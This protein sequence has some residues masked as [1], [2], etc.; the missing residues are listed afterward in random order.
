MFL[1]IITLME[2]LVIS[3]LKNEFLNDNYVIITDDDSA[4]LN[5]DYTKHY[6]LIFTIGTITIR[7]FKEFYSM[8]I[9][10]QPQ[11]IIF[12]V[13]NLEYFL[14]TMKEFRN[15][16]YNI[17]IESNKKQLV[18]SKSRKLKYIQLEKDIFKKYNSTSKQKIDFNKGIQLSFE[19]D[20]YKSIKTSLLNPQLYM[21]QP[22]SIS[23]IC[24]IIFDKKY[25]TIKDIIDNIKDEKDELIIKSLLFTGIIKIKGEK[26]VIN[27]LLK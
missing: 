26:V 17:Q 11:Q 1:Y 20:M 24:N 9:N 27:D 4:C 21:C 13:K 15:I 5:I 14:F 7:I 16:T 18:L 19:P 10:Q 25:E 8:N 2:I 3:S 23:K 12:I 6:I 22:T